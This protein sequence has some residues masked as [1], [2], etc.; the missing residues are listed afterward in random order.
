MNNTSL[1]DDAKLIESFAQGETQPLITKN[2]RIES[3]W[4][5]IQ[6]TT[7]KGEMIGILKMSEERPY[8]LTKYDSEYW[9]LIHQILIDNRFV[10][11]GKSNNQPGFFQYQK[12]DVPKGYKIRYTEAR[13]LWKTWWP[14]QRRQRRYEI[15]LDML[16]FRQNR[17]Y[18][19]QDIV[20]N[21][22]IFYVKTLVGEITLSMSDYIVWL[23]KVQDKQILPEPQ[24]LPNPEKN[25]LWESELPIEEDTSVTTP[26][27][28]PSKFT[29]QKAKTVATS[30]EKV[31]SQP[32]MS[33]DTET[34]IEKA[35]L[36]LKV[37]AIKVL[38]NYLENG[39][40]EITTEVIKDA[41]GKVTST[42]I[43]TSQ[44]PC[45][46]WVVE[47]LVK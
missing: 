47:I 27:P 16:V 43:V 39:A 42:K 3:A 14:K 29:P 31:K 36:Q 8:A 6:L 10:P 45:P 24:I 9:D 46:Q 37:K 32:A 5:T 2:L 17:W 23:E 1:M 35:L 40:T 22:A 41:S 12:H 15:Q 11:C 34:K 25:M 38:S 18:P 13:L 26:L 33:S 4:K 21:D 19:I 7:A 44:K 28:K 20:V 30:G